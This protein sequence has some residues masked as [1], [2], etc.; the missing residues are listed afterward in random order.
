VHLYQ[1]CNQKF[2]V[3]IRSTFIALQPVETEFLLRNFTTA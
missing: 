3:R 1:I 2:S